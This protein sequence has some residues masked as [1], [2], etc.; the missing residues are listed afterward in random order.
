MGKDELAD[1]QGVPIYPGAIAPEGQSS[2][3]QGNGETKY[4][5]ELATSDQIKKVNAF[6]VEKFPSASSV[7][8]AIGCDIMVQTPKGTYAQIKIGTK[9]GK[10]SI[11]VIAL[12]GDAPKPK[13]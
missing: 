8:N 12:V 1:K 2:V 3:T 11:S 5:L 10:T 4:D 9:E 7:C 13:Q 6:Y